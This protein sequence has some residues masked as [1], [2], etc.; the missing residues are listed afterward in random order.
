MPTPTTPTPYDPNTPPSTGPCTYVTPYLLNPKPLVS[1]THART[2]LLL[3][4]AINV[5]YVSLVPLAL[6]AATG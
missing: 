2:R 6:F 3:R 5:T 4:A 1:R